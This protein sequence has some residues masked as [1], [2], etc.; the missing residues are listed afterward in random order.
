M[1][2]S[3]H[4]LTG[5]CISSLEKCLF[6]SSASFV[7]VLVAKSCLLFWGPHGLQPATLLCS[8][9]FPGKNTGMGCHFLLQGIFLIQ[10]LSPSLLHWQADSFF[11]FFFSLQIFFIGKPC[12]AFIYCISNHC[13]FTFMKTLLSFSST[14]KLFQE[15]REI[16]NLNSEKVHHNYYCIAVVSAFSVFLK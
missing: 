2:A 8:Q 15:C 3:F 12:I 13:T 5:R 10:G 14:R 4:G 1:L 7:T 16:S 9:D 11:V 6:R